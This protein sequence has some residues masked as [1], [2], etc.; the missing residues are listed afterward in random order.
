MSRRDRLKAKYRKLEK[1]G[2][3]RRIPLPRHTHL[4]PLERF[5]EAERSEM[6]T[7]EK[8]TEVFDYGDVI[9]AIVLKAPQQLSLEAIQR[10]DVI[11]EAL[12]T[13]RANGNVLV[14][15]EREYEYLKNKIEAF[16]WVRWTRFT[17]GFVKAIQAAEQF[18][19]GKEE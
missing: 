7:E 4:I 5:S 6:E 10:C 3:M 11:N 14:L 2:K 16:T 13:A 9:E 18:T 15:E 8:R 19:P 17:S 12:E 1:E